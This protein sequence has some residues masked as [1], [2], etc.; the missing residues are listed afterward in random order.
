MPF[1]PRCGDKTVTTLESSWAPRPAA[2]AMRYSCSAAAASGSGI[3]ARATDA[4]HDPHVLD[5][6]VDARFDL[7]APGIGLQHA[8][9]AI[10]EH[11]RAGRALA[12]RRSPQLD[13]VLVHERRAMASAAAAMWTPARSWLIVFRA[14]PSPGRGPT[15]VSVDAR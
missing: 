14:W 8:R 2:S 5:K 6:D 11:E 10:G 3:V 4:G 12:A 9:S 13:R 15:I 7:G 1:F